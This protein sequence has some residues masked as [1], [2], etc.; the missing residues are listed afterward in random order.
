VEFQPRVASAYETEDGSRV[1][2]DIVLPFTRDEYAA[3]RLAIIELKRSR[4]QKRITLPLNFRGELVNLYDTVTLALPEATGTFRVVGKSSSTEGTVTVD[5]RQE[6]ESD[7]TYTVP[8]LATPPI[9]PSVVRLPSGPP[10]PTNLEWLPA[11]RGLNMVSLRWD[12]PNMAS[13]S[14]IEVWKS[15]DNNRANAIRIANTVSD[16]FDDRSSFDGG[17]VVGGYYWIISKGYNGQYSTWERPG[18]TDG[19]EGL[20]IYASLSSQWEPTTYTGFSTNPQGFFWYRIDGEIVSMRWA[21]NSP[22]ETNGANI[23]L[24]TM[25]VAIRP[26]A[27]RTVLLP[28]QVETASFGMMKSL[29]QAVIRT[30]GVIELW[31]PVS[32]PDGANNYP[33]WV[34]AQLADRD[35]SIATGANFSYSI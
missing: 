25:P 33:R 32:V 10:A 18:A 27:D 22:G 7:W 9:V 29:A 2:Q 26:P 11:N 21:A 19:V 6:A 15:P 17:G 34:Q 23:T 5:L 16:I 20:P 35:F 12:N 1:W 13:V 8:D 4:Q 30:T 28:V 14:H 24:G 3:Q 31:N